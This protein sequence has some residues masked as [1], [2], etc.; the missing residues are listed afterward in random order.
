MSQPEP[1]PRYPP[2]PMTGGGSRNRFV[3]SEALVLGVASTA[4][5]ALVVAALIATKGRQSLFRN[6]AEFFWLVARN[7]FAD[8]AIFRPFAH[9]MGDAYRYG[10]I[11]FPLLAWVLALGRPGAVQWTLILVDLISFGAV[12]ALAAELV[13]R[14]GATVERGLAVLLTPAMW[15]ALVL[16]VSEPF[17]LALVLAIYLLDQD[18]HRVGVLVL[19]ALLLLAREVA[20][21]ALVPLVVRDGRTGARA[22]MPW[23]LVAAPLLGWWAWVRLHV[24]DWPFLDPSISRRE[25]LA[26]PF[27]GP[28]TVIRAGAN[29]D[30]VVAFV[31]GAITVALGIWVAARRPWFPVSH[32]ALLFSCLVVVFGANAWRYP[33]EA[34]RLMGPAQAL[35]LLC[36]VTWRGGSDGAPGKP[37]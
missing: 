10:R 4:V 23:L 29:S 3:R 34:I 6:D 19:G 26:L 17:V 30:H 21:L 27:A 37:A 12:V 24:G 13:A 32:A 5:A 16:A 31:L 20:V 18:G 11:L 14:R 15:F 2:G 7:P 25:A 8:G 22:A 36:V 28:A 35:A 1:A 9:E 33:G